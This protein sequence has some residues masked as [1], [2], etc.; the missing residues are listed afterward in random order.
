[1]NV[2]AIETSGRVGSVAACRDG[3]GVAEEALGAGT[4]H[5]R[6][7]LP[8]VD[9]V[10]REAGWDKLRDIDLVAVGRGP[11]SFTGLRV[12]L[13]CAKMLAVLLGKPLVGVCSLDAMAENAPVDADHIVTVLDAKRGDV[14]AAAY[15][16]RDGRL[17]RTQ[18]PDAMRPGRARALLAEPLYVMGDALERHAGVFAG[19]A[20]RRAPEEEWRIHARVVARLAVEA[21]RAG[22]ADDP[23]G[24]EPIYLRRP[25]AEEK[26]LARERGA[27]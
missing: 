6:M 17:V 27:T 26:R 16:R 19:P 4:T 15:E 21:H 5:G 18:P 20:C 10:V 23:I 7:L 25:E 11:G 8:I 22:H 14:Y 2:L 9:R 3:E 24:M 12:G 13:T 1:M